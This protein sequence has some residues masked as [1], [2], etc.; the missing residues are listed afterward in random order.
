MGLAA[1]HQG[2]LVQP[3]EAL[4]VQACSGNSGAHG[5]P[6]SSVALSVTGQ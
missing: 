1:V 2:D 3:C 5:I 6:T 4:G